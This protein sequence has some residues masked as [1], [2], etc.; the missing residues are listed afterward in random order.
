[1]ATL[2]VLATATLHPNGAS[3]MATVVNSGRVAAGSCVGSNICWPL[4]S[5]QGLWD[6]LFSLVYLVACCTMDITFF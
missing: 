6:F 2:S 4:V 3:A 1:M 5:P